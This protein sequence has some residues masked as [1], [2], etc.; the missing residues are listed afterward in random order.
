[1]SLP[2]ETQW[3]G[4]AIPS[5]KDVIPNAKAVSAEPTEAENIDLS[6]Y[7]AR[8]ATLLDR[9]ITSQRLAL[10]PGADP[11]KH[12]EF[13]SK[14]ALSQ[15]DA[16]MLGFKPAQIVTEDGSPESLHSAADGT[17]CVGDVMLMELPKDH[18]RVIDEVY[19]ERIERKHGKPGQQQ[20]EQREERQMKTDFETQVGLRTID[21]PEGQSTATPVNA[22]EI[23]QKLQ[24]ND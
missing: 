21:T 13:I 23:R 6:K 2:R 8:I 20:N 18:K 10:P 9:G 4:S 3:G 24:T 15:A 1:M 7:K 17:Y 5:K 14:D 12:Y 11:T 22:V 19:R 16:R